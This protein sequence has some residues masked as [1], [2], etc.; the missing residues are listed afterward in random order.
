LTSALAYAEIGAQLADI[1]G[2]LG[3][4]EWVIREAE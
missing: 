2:R 4:M 1:N 3:H